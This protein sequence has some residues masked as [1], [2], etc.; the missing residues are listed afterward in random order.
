VTVDRT[1]TGFWKAIVAEPDDDT[2]RL[3]FADWL[4]DNGDPDRAE[5]IRLQCKLAGMDG[6]EPEWTEHRVREQL[7]LAEHREAWLAEMPKWTQTKIERF[8]R[9][10]PSRLSCTYSEYARSGASLARDTVIDEVDLRGHRNASISDAITASPHAPRLRF[11]TETNTQAELMRLLPAMTGLRELHLVCPLWDTQPWEHLGP[12]LRLPVFQ[13]LRCL[14]LSMGQEPR[15]CSEVSGQLAQVDLPALASFRFYTPPA[16]SGWGLAQL[17]AAPFVPGLRELI[18]TGP[19]GA[20]EARP[21]ADALGL[22]GLRRLGLR[23]PPVEPAALATVLASPHLS[24]LSALVVLGVNDGHLEVLEAADVTPRLR[25]LHLWS[26]DSRISGVTRAGV[27]R[28]VNSGRLAGLFR[29]GLAQVRASEA[30]VEMLAR[31]PHLPE[32]RSLE[33]YRCP[34]GETPEALATSPQL[35]ALR[36]ISGGGW[37]KD[38]ARPYNQ[39][40]ALLPER[41]WWQD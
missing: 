21:L 28:L 19:V 3:V 15:I 27:E 6:T 24:N 20:T 23:I 31:T 38:Q 25:T 37:C 22:T 11:F 2:H 17:L 35:P 9:G 16:V 41:G 18:L 30:V 33:L 13:V 5:F 32:L 34:G 36:A 29:L 1:G 8:R 40:L 7:L 10:F 26:P 14:S 4:D 12:L 39:R